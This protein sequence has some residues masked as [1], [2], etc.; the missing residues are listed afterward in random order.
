M[1]TSI[2]LPYNSNT[3]VPQ[4]MIGPMPTTMGNSLEMVSRYGPANSYLQNPD[5]LQMVSKYFY[6]YIPDVPDKTDP[7]W[8][9][10]QPSHQPFN[11]PFIQDVPDKTDPW[12]PDIQDVPDKTDPWFPDITTDTWI[13]LQPSHQPFHMQFMPEPIEDVPDKVDPWLPLQPSHQPFNA[14]FIQDVPDKL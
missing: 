4:G 6:P 13:P 1:L 9:P 7:W 14:P 12:P 11:T 3:N 10:L 2:G 8:I 5:L